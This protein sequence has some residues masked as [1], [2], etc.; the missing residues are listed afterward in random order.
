MKIQVKQND[1]SGGL[2]LV[3]AAVRSKVLPVLANVLLAV[4]DDRLRLYATDLEM[5]VACSIEPAHIEKAGSIS[6][7]AR[8]FADLVATL[9]G[10]ESVSL[11][12]DT[13]RAANNG[14]TPVRDG[15]E[16]QTLLVS[17]GDSHTKIKGIDANEFPPFPE[18]VGSPSVRVTAAAL[19]KAIRQ[20]AFATSRDESRPILAGVLLEASDGN[21]LTL[22]AADGFR[23]SR[24]QVEANVVLPGAKAVVPVRALNILAKSVPDD[25]DVS[26]WFAANQVIFAASGV[27]VAAQVIDGNYPDV[28]AILGVPTPTTVSVNRDALVAA[29]RQALVVARE[30][31]NALRLRIAPGNGNGD[32]GKIHLEAEAA[33][34]GRSESH[35]EGDVSGEAVRLGVNVAFLLDAISCTEAAKASIGFGGANTPVRVI[36][37]GLVQVIMPLS[38]PANPD[39]P[40]P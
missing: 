33:Q 28:T 34:V 27:R 24:R 40:S 36:D 5:S 7:P 38:V 23:L 10:G 39:N 19:K 32:S 15:S 37:G 13:V 12:L 20:T 8:T 35:V 31:G 26:I 6:V 18:A 11:E 21:N 9:P 30:G 2:N 14:G 17:C 25:A 22:T 4:E 3:S 29:C 16:T 1:L